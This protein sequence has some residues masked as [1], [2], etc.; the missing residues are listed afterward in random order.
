MTHTEQAAKWYP[1][2]PA[3]VPPP[4]D[5][6]RET[7]E[8]LEMSQSKLATRT[9]F[10]LKHVNQIVQGNASITPVT[11]IALER[12]TSVP[13]S[14]WNTLEADYQDHKVRTDEVDAL[15]RQSKWLE[16]MPIKDLRDRGFVTATKR[17]P[18]RLLQEVLTFF[19]VASITAWEIAWDQPAA[20]FLQSSAYK[21]D[22]GAVSA[23]LRL[24]E[25]A[26]DELAQTQ[27]F[28]LFDRSALKSALPT[29]REMTVKDPKEFFADLI[30]VL[31]RAGVCLVVV[32]DVG[33]TRASG[34][35]RFVSPTR[36][37]V[38]LSNRGKRN[39][40]F[41]FALFHELAHLLLHSKKDTF[42]R[43]DDTAAGGAGA[44]VEQEANDYA[45]RFLIPIEAESE[46]LA[47]RS[48]SDAK[49]LANRLGVAPGIVAGR[50]QRES[51]N[52][53]FG[54]SPSLFQ[55]YA[56]TD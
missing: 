35:S 41:W 40:K 45:G 17:E 18:G 21:I 19:G 23:W 10:T 14:F 43:F 6:L 42:M 2:I 53:S 13:A 12:A 56:I 8:E 38:Q 15:G 27:A 32:P 29:I 49:A 50:F 37:V 28:E 44:E 4:G 20:A 24:G 26:A 16:R 31:A 55:K 25:L 9:G 51:E 22:P 36:A 34:A 52:W 3:I 48:P 11:A 54:T 46:L 47:I 1:H 30:A 7:L 5:T 39:D 33:G